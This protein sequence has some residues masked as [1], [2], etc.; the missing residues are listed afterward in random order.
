MEQ[1]QATIIVVPGLSCI[2][3]PC[4]T[5]FSPKTRSSTAAYCLLSFC[6][7][8]IVIYLLDVVEN[9]K[10]WHWLYIVGPNRS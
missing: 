6:K 8:M 2:E 7:P 9:R 3:L 4:V 5:S 10:T 1:L